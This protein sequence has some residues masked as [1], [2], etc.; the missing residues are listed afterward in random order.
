MPC[1]PSLSLPVLFSP[2]RATKPPERCPKRDSQAKR[3]RVTKA[4]TWCSVCEWAGVKV[5]Y[6]ATFE[7]SAL[8]P[9]SSVSPNR[10]VAGWNWLIWLACVWK[11]KG[12]KKRDHLPPG[13]LPSPADGGAVGFAV[14]AQ[15][16]APGCTWV[17]SIATARPETA[18][19]SAPTEAS[20]P[21]ATRTVL[22]RTS[23]VHRNVTKI[24]ER[25]NE[26]K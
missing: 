9:W 10:P 24:K 17:L 2:R 8:G 22:C 1:S 12:K 11:T 3:R 26:N 19:N 15:L 16:G 4:R 6:Q 14:Q 25:G 7:K 13:S 20:A 18:A 21:T 23:V 5:Y